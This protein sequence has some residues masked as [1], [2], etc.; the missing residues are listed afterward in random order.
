MSGVNNSAEYQ[1]AG[2]ILQ[3]TRS[4]GNEY[5]AEANYIFNGEYL[6]ARPTYAATRPQTR[7]HNYFFG[8]SGP[9]FIPGLYN[10]KDKTFFYFNYEDSKSPAGSTSIFNV[11]TNAMRAGNFSAFSTP[12][13]DPLTGQPFPGNIIPTT[14]LNA[15]SLKYLERFYPPSNAGDPNSP[16]S[17]FNGIW[18][19][20]LGTPVYTLRVDQKLAERTTLWYRLFYSN[21]KQHQDDNAI[22]TQYLG[23]HYNDQVNQ[24]H[25]LATTHTF[26]PTIVNETRLGYIRITKLNGNDNLDGAQIVRRDRSDRLS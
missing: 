15:A 1:Y 26:S 18:R 17:N 25:V 5:H 9:V 7:Y 14:R 6:N 8:G 24:N 16:A 21:Q 13:I 23:F 2:L 22:P 19:A 20:D 4:G 3:T 10:G 11:P 12:V